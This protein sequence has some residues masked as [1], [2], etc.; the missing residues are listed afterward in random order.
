MSETVTTPAN[1]DATA[2]KTFTQ[3]QVDQIV[4]DRLTRDREARKSD[5]ELSAQ[6]LQA[7][8]EA[9]TAKLTEATE[10]IK[11]LEGTSATAAEVSA[12]VEE[13][14]KQIEAAVAEDKRKLIPA[15]YS[16]A[17]KI[18]Y[19]AQ[20]KELFFPAISAQVPTPA[21]PAPHNLSGTQGESK[22]NGYA[23]LLEF[24]QRDPVGYLKAQKEGR[25]R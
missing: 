14:W 18:E 3:E 6:E 10:K 11:T 5:A 19:L 2:A 20:N 8:V 21:T 24:A 13:S 22:L 7:K 25:F 9:A 1:A 16:A 23:S 15:K 12:K 4:K 17:E